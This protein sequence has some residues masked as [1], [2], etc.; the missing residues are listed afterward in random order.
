MI[1]KK[2]KENRYLPSAVGISEVDAD[3]G[4]TLANNNKKLAGGSR[5]SKESINIK[6]K[7][8]MQLNSLKEYHPGSNSSCEYARTFI[9]GHCGVRMHTTQPSAHVV[10]TN[11]DSV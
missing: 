4:K 7:I 10:E 1:K 2:K 8:K 11:Q 9:N 6:S 5:R 3:L